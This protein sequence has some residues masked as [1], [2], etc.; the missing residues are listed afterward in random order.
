MMPNPERQALPTLC[1]ATAHA[2]SVWLASHHASSR[3]VWL[4]IAKKGAK[5]V[6]VTYAE[7]LEVALTW[8]WIDGQKGK[9]DDAWWLQKFTPR[10][11]KSIW[12]KINREKVAALIEVGSMQ[13]PGLAEVE[14]AKRDG[15]WQAAYASQSRTTVPPDFAKAL[16]ANPSA[17]RFFETLDSRNRYAILFRVHTAKNPETRVKRIEKFIGMLAR[18]EKLHS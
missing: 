7:A 17:F 5:S 15:R 9:F 14:R 3:G 10:G 13:P 1:F 18:G 4:K 8:G 11:P 12:S 16:A 2:W 6:S